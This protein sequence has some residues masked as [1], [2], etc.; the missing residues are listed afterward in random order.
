MENN[1][2]I[3][4]GYIPI[5]FSENKSNKKSLFNRILFVILLIVVILYFY[6]MIYKK[7]QDDDQPTEISIETS[8]NENQEDEVIDSS[9][10]NNFIDS[11]TFKYELEC[12]ETECP[13]L[14]CGDNEILLRKRDQ[15]CQECVK[16]SN[17]TTSD[18][19]QFQERL[20][21]LNQFVNK[22]ISEIDFN[23]NLNDIGRNTTKVTFSLID[24]LASFN[25]SRFNLLEFMNIFNQKDELIYV[26]IIFIFFGII[27]Y[28]FFN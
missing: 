14:S 20:K 9:F 19:S 28:L 24:R 21:K 10:T 5:K 15:C 22:N 27:L 26:G 8:S 25:Y 18:E 4:P 6:F 23:A 3:P 16:I 7:Y 13:D 1:L 2:S 11:S 17:D 12:A